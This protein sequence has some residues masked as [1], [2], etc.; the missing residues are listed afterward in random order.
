MLTAAGAEFLATSECQNI[1]IFAGQKEEKKER[2]INTG[3]VC[4]CGKEEKV[5]KVH[6]FNIYT[7]SGI[8]QCQGSETM[9]LL[10][11]R[12]ADR[13]KDGQDV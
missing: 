8:S 2:N 12:A 6:L 3:S 1:N 10:S 13:M 5:K 4:S 7:F 9:M 11:E